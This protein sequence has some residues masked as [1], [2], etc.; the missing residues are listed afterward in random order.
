M[1][2]VKHVVNIHYMHTMY[3]ECVVLYENA[4]Q[5]LRFSNCFSAKEY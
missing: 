1:I 2:S 5:Y 4:L 3:V